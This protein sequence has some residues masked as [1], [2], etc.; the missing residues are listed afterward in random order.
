MMKEE[1]ISVNLDELKKFKEQN[2][3]ERLWFVDFWVNYI[4]THSDKEWSRQQNIV[5]GSQINAGAQSQ[6]A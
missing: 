6:T 3:K 1:D 2:A 4:K 5:I